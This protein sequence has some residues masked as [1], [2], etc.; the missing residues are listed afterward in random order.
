MW[1]DVLWP[2]LHYTGANDMYYGAIF[3]S[4][5]A[6]VEV[7]QNASWVT[8]AIEVL[9]LSPCLVVALLPILALV[10]L[11]I[12][13]SDLISNRLPW[14]I[15]SYDLLV[16]A[17]A[18]GAALSLFVKKRPDVAQMIF[19]EPLLILVLVWILERRRPIRWLPGA[20]TPELVGV[21][22]L[23]FTA[24]GAMFL[25]GSLL[26][27]L[28]VKTRRGNL[29][30]EY[31]NVA[32]AYLMANTYPGE[33]IFVYPYAANLYFLTDTYSPTQ[34]DYL[35]P[36]MHTREQFEKAVRAVE[37]NRTS[38]IM[39]DLGFFTNQVPQSWPFTP[40]ASL[41]E[42]PLRNLLISAYRPCAVVGGDRDRFVAFWRKDLPCPPNP[43]P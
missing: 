34:F 29:R 37:R 19:V 3:H 36:G 43:T 2:L 38:L 16:S 14:K 24:F 22:L 23:L 10:A 9:V 33:T 25:R 21:L 11:A 32:L 35:Q 8:R 6:W 41:A 4:Y 7:F 20:G 40:P 1:S 28:T 13:I 26:Q 39:Y 42:E 31:R 5:Q 27:P 12:C 18:C 30:A 17:V 15:V